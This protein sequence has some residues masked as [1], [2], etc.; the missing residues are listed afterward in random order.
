MGEKEN[1]KKPIRAR[2]KML[3]FENNIDN[4]PNDEYNCK[5]T[6]KI[7]ILNINHFYTSKYM[8][9]LYTQAF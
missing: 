3:F 6:I 5:P 8:L 7:N 9:F 4:Y 2:V 1:K